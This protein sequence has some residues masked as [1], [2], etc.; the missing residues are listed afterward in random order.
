MPTASRTKTSAP[1]SSRSAPLKA[2]T[3]PLLAWGVPVAAGG[4]I[5]VSAVLA[6]FEILTTDV[7][8]AVSIVAALILLVFLGE[9]PL[10]APQA[11]TRL[12]GIGIGLAIVW[13][14]ACYWPFHS[15]L[16]PGTPL[17]NATR[18]TP[19]GD[20]LPLTIPA[21]GHGLIDLLVEGQLVQAPGS[22]V[23]QPLTY[24]LTFEPT[25]SAPLTISGR[26]D[27][28]LKTQ[29]MGRRGTT[30]VHQ[31]HTAELH[32][33]ENA[34]QGEL[35]LT[36]VTLEPQSAAGLTVSA[37]VHPLPPTWGL[38][39]LVAALL[40]GTLAFDRQALVASTD[41]ALTLSTAAVVSTAIIFWTSNTP[42]PEFST[43]IGSTML[44][45]PLGYLAGAAIWWI[46][47]LILGRPGR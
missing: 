32:L 13:F 38:V 20:G 16:F 29:R 43:L 33:V 30:Q 36:Q 1:T 28:T 21:S 23:A 41:G 7:A 46:A 2:P 26:F 4:V 14:G 25:G 8:L 27:D 15:R 10:L 3:N 39:L 9:R 35:R 37:F 17:V 18:V 6:L 19:A 5:L 11:D 44:G 24:T 31:Q 45:A 34:G 12:R 22:S 42:H 40:A 47:K